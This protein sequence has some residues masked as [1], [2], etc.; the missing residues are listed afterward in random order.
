[1]SFTRVQMVPCM[2]LPVTQEDNILLLVV[3]IVIVV[4]DIVVLVDDVG[5][6]GYHFKSK[7]K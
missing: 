5:Q 6:V 2:G 7:T 3:V 1:M 4:D